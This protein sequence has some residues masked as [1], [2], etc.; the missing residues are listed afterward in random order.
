MRKL[1][2]GTA[3]FVSCLTFGVCFGATQGVTTAERALATELNAR[4]TEKRTTDPKLALELARIYLRRAYIVDLDPA[5]AIALELLNPDLRLKEQE[6]LQ[7]FA[8]SLDALARGAA[9]GDITTLIR[10]VLT[11]NYL[12]ADK[13]QF[14]RWFIGVASQHISPIPVLQ[15][16]KTATDNGMTGKRRRDFVAWIIALV[17]KGEDPIHIKTIYDAVRRVAPLFTFQTD[18]LTKC[19][20]AVRIGASPSI[21]ADAVERMAKRHKIP[22]AM[23]EDLAKLLDLFNAGTP[24][25]EAVQ[26]VAPGAAD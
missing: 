21:L 10:E 9:L 18:F 13:D 14:F 25:E 2:F 4:L 6:Q 16:T 12:A 26:M 8:A 24:L 17:E 20:D 3:L 23:E 22:K 11:A 7:Y 15:V 5:R 19:Y 1:P